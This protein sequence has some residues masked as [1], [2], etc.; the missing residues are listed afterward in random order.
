[1]TITRAEILAALRKL[2]AREPSTLRDLALACLLNQHAALKTQEA[3][4]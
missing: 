2:L 3:A 4:R 1:M